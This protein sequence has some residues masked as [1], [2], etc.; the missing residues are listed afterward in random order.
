MFL[1]L[2]MFAQR[3][4]NLTQPQSSASLRQSRQ[5]QNR[6][7]EFEPGAHAFRRCTDGEFA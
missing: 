6:R 5:L 7:R 4:K 2:E 1:I 3:V